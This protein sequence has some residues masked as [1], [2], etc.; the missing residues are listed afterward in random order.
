FLREGERMRDAVVAD[1]QRI[2]G[3][4]FVP[5]ES[6]ADYYLII[7]PE[8]DDHLRRL[9]Q[10]VLNRG[11]RLLGSQPSAI[12]MVSDKLGL[13]SHWSVENVLHARTELADA[14]TIECAKFPCIIKPRCGA[15]SQATFLVHDRKACIEAW[16]AARSEWPGRDLI[17]QD[18]LAG[19]SV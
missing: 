3:V 15:G 6:H 2:A 7:A 5:L 17:V 4:E 16:L 12:A 11:G 9:S 18:Y 19:Q 14:R 1:L 13:A 8:F 10:A